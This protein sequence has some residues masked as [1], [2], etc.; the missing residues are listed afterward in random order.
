M[1][2]EADRVQDGKLIARIARWRRIALTSAVLLV[3]CAVALLVLVIRQSRDS[4]GQ[5][6]D[7]TPAP[8]TPDDR[9]E[10]VVLAVRR[11][12][13][14]RVVAGEAGKL[15]SELAGV[16]IHSAR[17]LIT[18]DRVHLEPL[19]A[20]LA[21]GQKQI[22]QLRVLVAEPDQRALLD[23]AER[24]LRNYESKYDRLVHVAGG[25]KDFSTA[26]VQLDDVIES[27]VLQPIDE[28]AGDADRRL[29]ERVTELEA[30][31]K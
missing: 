11:V 3:L 19:P 1:E 9:L 2:A 26:F 14:A 5:S 17:Y 27:E 21:R 23:R 30:A 12:A 29:A 4:T 24:G 8:T 31:I 13:E 7:P 28:L 15:R 22:H 16:K 20:M 25:R 18:L 10:R 6:A